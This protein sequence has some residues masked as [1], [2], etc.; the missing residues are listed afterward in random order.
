MDESD[1]D[2]Q[3]VRGTIVFPP[4]QRPEEPFTVIVQLE[5]VS[6]MDAPSRILAEV[7]L[8]NRDFGAGRG[9]ELP[10]R[11]PFPTELLDPA[12]AGPLRL[13]LRVHVRHTAVSHEPASRGIMTHVDVTEGDF[14]STQSHPVPRG[15]ALVRIPVQR[16]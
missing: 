8:A 11:L 2:A 1:D 16:V 13:N 6:R 10:F 12:K 4:A 15:G 7:R 14:V 9:R 3:T 5:D